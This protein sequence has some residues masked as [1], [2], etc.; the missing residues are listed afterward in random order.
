MKTNDFLLDR[1][2]Y[3]DLPL[4]IWLFFTIKMNTYLQIV[5]RVIYLFELCVSVCLKN[6]KHTVLF[7]YKM[8]MDCQ[9]RF[10]FLIYETEFVLF[11]AVLE[12][13]VLPIG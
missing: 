11:L 10:C 9:S 1:E 6:S 4:I 12:N 3:F 2:G 7:L 13:S 8:K 5:L